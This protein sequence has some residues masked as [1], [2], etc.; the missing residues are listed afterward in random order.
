MSVYLTLALFIAIA[1]VAFELNAEVPPENRAFAV[2]R[3]KDGI[4]D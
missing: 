4:E 1:W 3:W 2:D